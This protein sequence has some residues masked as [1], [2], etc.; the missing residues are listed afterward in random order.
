MSPAKQ[1]DGWG[2]D[3]NAW[4][5][6]RQAKPQ[7][8]NKEAHHDVTAQE[9]PA[10]IHTATPKPASETPAECK[11]CTVRPDCGK[12]MKL[13]GQRRP[14]PELVRG[15]VRLVDKHAADMVCLSKLPEA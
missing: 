4:W 15:W 8:A 14:R 11:N 6:S 1:T 3:Y 10:V 13:W 12:I 7:N 5:K 9:K 2:S